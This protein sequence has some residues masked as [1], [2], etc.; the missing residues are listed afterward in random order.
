MTL[1]EFVQ[2]ARSH[3]FHAVELYLPWLKESASEIAR[4]CDENGLK[5]IAHIS[6]EGVSVDEHV[7]H[8]E[9]W[10]AR[11]VECG[12]SQ[13]NSHTGR[14]FFSFES[15]AKIFGR[16]LDLE[17]A[18]GIRISHETHR[19]RALFAAHVCDSFLKRFPELTLTADF[20]HWVC[21]SESDLRGQQFAIDAAIARTTHVH[22]RVGYDQGPQVRDPRDELYSQWL[23]RF[24]EFWVAIAGSALERGLER[25]YFTP[26]FGPPPYAEGAAWD[27]GVVSKIWEI[28]LWIRDLLRERLGL[29]AAD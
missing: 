22:A 11:A 5:L 18:S 24:E 9:R 12:A 7:D 17:R 15:N 4:L 21:V 29:A 20:S 19:A 8:L 2:S 14:D 23:A 1:E 10:F 28:N 6:S 26:E 27:T 16:A 25:L 13:V 3:K